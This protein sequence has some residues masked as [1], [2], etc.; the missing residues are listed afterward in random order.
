[1]CLNLLLG[2]VVW[3]FIT[4]AIIKLCSSEAI[5]LPKQFLAMEIYLQWLSPR[6]MRVQDP[7][8]RV[9][10]YFGLTLELEKLHFWWFVSWF[11][12]CITRKPIFLGVFIFFLVRKVGRSFRKT[13]YDRSMIVGWS[14]IN[15]SWL[16]L[17]FH[18]ELVVEFDEVC[19]VSWRKFY[20]VTTRAL[21]SIRCLCFGRILFHWNLKLNFG[22]LIWI[23]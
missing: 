16:K 8:L 11:W 5:N 9:L 20:F 2:V 12:I 10:S 21:W 13:F 23:L 3:E 7:F 17:G 1:M 22:F 6:W 4:R 18:E 14:I 19:F 15:L